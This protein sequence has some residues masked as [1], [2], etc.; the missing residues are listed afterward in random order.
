M[1]DKQGNSNGLEW[2]EINAEVNIMLNAGSTTT[3][4]AMANVLY[5]LLKHPKVMK[6][7]RKEIDSVLEAD[8]VIASYDKVKN[9]PFLRA[10]LDESLRFSPTTHGLGRETPP[11]WMTSL[12][13][14]SLLACRPTSCTATKPSFQK[15]INSFRRDGSER[16]GKNCSHISSLFLLELVDALGGIYHI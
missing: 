1:E 7:L 15:L 14:A 2:G 3:A 4:I 11:D 8:E 13:V 9:L 12:A 10:C 16:K 6:R 5:Q